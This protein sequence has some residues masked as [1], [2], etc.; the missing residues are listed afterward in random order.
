MPQQ[1]G[2]RAS[3]L[4][5]CSIPVP[6]RIQDSGNQQNVE[7]AM[8]WR[9][10]EMER[11]YTERAQVI[12]TGKIRVETKRQV[13]RKNWTRRQEEESSDGNERCPSVGSLANRKFSARFHF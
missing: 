1:F 13:M 9:K 2:Q 4:A 3:K 12:E 8:Y 5:P 6:S 7:R 11:S 10:K